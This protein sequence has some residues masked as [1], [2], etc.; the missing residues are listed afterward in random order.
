MQNVL[1]GSRYVGNSP[2]ITSGYLHPQIKHNLQQ[3]EAESYYS[4]ILNQ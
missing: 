3:S 1:N 4:R 2:H